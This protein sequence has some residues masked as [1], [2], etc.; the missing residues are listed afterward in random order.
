MR[1]VEAD[2]LKKTANLDI[3]YWLE[4]NR[5]SQRCVRKVEVTNIPMTM[6]TQAAEL[7][8]FDKSFLTKI[9]RAKKMKIQDGCTNDG[10][11]NLVENNEKPPY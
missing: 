1:P 10:S 11:S 6:M 3:A 5:I 2:L 7:E 9:I 8:C 4:H